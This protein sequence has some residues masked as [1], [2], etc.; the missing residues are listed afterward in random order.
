MRSDQACLQG[1][2]TLL[3]VNSTVVVEHEYGREV[4][5]E[6]WRYYPDDNPPRGLHPGDTRAALAPYLA[7]HVRGALACYLQP[8]RQAHSPYRI[9]TQVYGDSFKWVLYGDDDTMFFIDG[10]LD[11]VQTLDADLPYFITGAAWNA[12]GLDQTIAR[13][14]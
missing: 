8:S 4:S 9:L 5:H 2:R 13:L 1:I 6:S 12:H 14:S 11:L 3:A 10:V 7:H